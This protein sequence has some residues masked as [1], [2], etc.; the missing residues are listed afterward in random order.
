MSLTGMSIPFLVSSAIILLKM[1]HV[2]IRSIHS[3]TVVES[4]LRSSVWLPLVST[5]WLPTTIKDQ[6][7]SV[8]LLYFFDYGKG[9]QHSLLSRLDYPPVRT[10]ECVN[11]ERQPIHLPPAGSAGFATCSINRNF[12]AILFEFLPSFESFVVANL[13]AKYCQQR[14]MPRATRKTASYRVVF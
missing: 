12:A 7:S 11:G 9:R 5:F 6:P 3:S 14:M 8:L 1:L 13:A 10:D 2:S 4:C